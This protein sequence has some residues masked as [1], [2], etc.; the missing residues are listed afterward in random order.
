LDKLQHHLAKERDKHFKFERLCEDGNV[1]IR[2]D[3]MDADS[4]IGKLVI[5]AHDP[6]EIWRCLKYHYGETYFNLVIEREMGVTSEFK[7]KLY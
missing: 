6:F 7:E 3:E 2:L 1:L 5:V 4:M